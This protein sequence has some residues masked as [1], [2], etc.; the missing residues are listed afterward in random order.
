LTLLVLVLVAIATILASRSWRRGLEW[1]LILVV[2]EGAIRKWVAPGAASYVYFAKDFLILGVYSGFLRDPTRRRLHAAVAP[3]IEVALGIAAAITLLQIFN[4]QL[5]SPLVGV[6]GFKAYFLYVP[7]LWV[8]PAAFRTADELKGWMRRYLLLSIPVGALAAA[9]FFSSADSALNT[10]AR[11][12]TETADIITFGAVER[13]RVTGTFSFITGYSSYLQVISLLALSALTLRSWRFRGSL[14]T[15]AGFAITVMGMLMSGSRGPVFLMILILPIYWV[16]GVARAGGVP[17]IGRFLLGAGLVASIVNVV[18][19][20]A[21]SAFRARAAGSSDVAGR[22]LL[23][24]INPL[25]IL[26]DIGLMGYG[27]GAT[28]Q[29]AEVVAPSL[30]PYSWLEGHHYEDEPSRVMVELG[31]VGFLAFFAA[32][33][34]LVALAMAALFRVRGQLERAIVLSSLLLFLAQLT[35]GVVF[36]VTAGVYYWFFGGLLFLALRLD[37]ESRV[38]AQFSA[39]GGAR[40]PAIAGPAGRG[41]SVS[42][43]A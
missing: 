1:V 4:P 41:R 36:N 25:R 13:V 21:V 11:G 29:M 40:G 16:F 9:Q 31:P 24:F 34:G 12:G 43:L 15:Y 5:P 10:Y 35:G 14:M 6:L 23:P 32:R 22:I 33:L 27:T 19:A 17:A 37:R 38:A 30:F 18:G 2:L 3:G 20:D 28:H 7:L 39:P 42:R 8:V 26:P